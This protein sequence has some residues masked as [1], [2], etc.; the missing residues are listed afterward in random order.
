MFSKSVT[1]GSVFALLAVAG[2]ILA[3][4]PEGQLE[5]VRRLN[6]I[7]AQKVEADV[8]SALRDAERWTPTDPAR[9]V[10][11]LK[12]TLAML[13]DDTYLS[14]LRRDT[15]VRTVKARLRPAQALAARLGDRN[16]AQPP[17]VARPD[18][19][20]AAEQE[21]IS[22]ALET[23]RL[24]RKDGKNAEAQRLADDLARQYPDH[25]AVQ[26]AVR[27]TTVAGQ[28]DA[29]RTFGTE[30][31]RGIVANARDVERSGTAPLGE[32]EFPKDWR[33]RIKLRTV[34]T[35]LTAKEKAILRA[36]DT[37]LTLKFKD[38]HFDEVIKYLS[39]RMGQPI[40]VDKLALKDAQIEYDTPVTIE[41]RGL[42]ARTVLRK[43]LGEVGLAYIIKD[44][45]IE[46]TTALKAK[47]TM[48]V[49]S[50]YIGDLLQPGGG[51]GGF[52]GLQLYG[53]AATQSQLT[54]QISQLIEMIQSSMDPSSW[55]TNGG[56]GTIV[57]HAPTLSLIIKQ[58]AEVH[59][60]IAGGMSR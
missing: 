14:D 40:V 33:E 5:R 29:A 34:G 22:H 59:N 47:E 44:Q 57:F 32:V 45:A 38:E 18:E 51:L 26:A 2:A 19:A 48:V 9:A 3:Q 54:L 7:A 58:S 25:P 27:S 11:R 4:A 28:L 13:A 21:R 30:R 15:L 6:E 35:P 56:S 52:L 46:V 20:R 55:Q 60:M 36:L 42:A 37:P 23:M 50:Y 41:A 12:A 31:D 49:R 10:E 43:I 1:T 8:Q 17:R 39:D 53:P 24:L 16:N